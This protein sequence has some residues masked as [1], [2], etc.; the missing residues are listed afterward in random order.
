MCSDA[1][2][3]VKLLCGREYGFSECNPR[4]IELHKLSSA[5]LQG[6]PTNNLDAERDLS[7]FSRLSQVAKYRNS[8]FTAKGIRN[9]M[10]LYK[11]K[12]VEVQRHFEKDK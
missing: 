5:E 3:G 9:D 8:K 2:E 7:K 11:S 4:A 12:Q 1:A 10:T 6:L